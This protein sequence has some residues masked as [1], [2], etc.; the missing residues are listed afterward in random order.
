M[1]TSN[2][3]KMLSSKEALKELIVWDNSAVLATKNVSLGEMYHT[4]AYQ[5]PSSSIMN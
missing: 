4:F 5:S 2:E 3:R 1:P